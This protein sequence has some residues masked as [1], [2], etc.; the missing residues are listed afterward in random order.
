MNI[1]KKNWDRQE[2]EK[3]YETHSIEEI[4][5]IYGYSKA[6][7][8]KVMIRLEIPMSTRH[9][10]RGKKGPEPF[11]KTIDDYLANK[12]KKSKRDSLRQVAKRFLDLA[13]CSE[14][15]STQNVEIHHINYPATF[16][17]D[18]QILCNSCHKIKHKK[19]ITYEKQLL[20]HNQ[21]KNGARTTEL[22]KQF[23]VHRSMIYFIIRKIE[24]GAKTYTEVR[25]QFPLSK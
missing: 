2:V 9:L 18:I 20:I 6:G 22:A 16:I 1:K 15:G 13:H 7:M 19:G 4:G 24:T 3:L 12:K 10:G 25:N 21:H 5:E 11:F 14:C 8:H 17:T 23:G